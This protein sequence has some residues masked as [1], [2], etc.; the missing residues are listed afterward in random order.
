MR[1][2]FKSKKKVGTSERHF[3]LA[4]QR[5][6]AEAK[7][8]DPDKRFLKTWKINDHTYKVRS[9][10]D[11]SVWHIVKIGD[12]GPLRCDCTAFYYRNACT[13]S[14]AVVRRLLRG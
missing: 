8:L 10:S 13:H 7:G 1:L 9:R 6:E 5:A 11:D 3:D 14:A 12:G 2:R 4:M